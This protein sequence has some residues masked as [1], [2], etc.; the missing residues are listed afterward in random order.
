MMT[1]MKL[2]KPLLNTIAAIMLLSVSNLAFSA[3][4]LIVSGGGYKKPMQAIIAEYQAQTGKQV[5]ASFGNMRQITSQAQASSKIALA[6]G[7]EKFFN[8]TQDLFS[9]S[10]PI[11]EGKLVIAWAQNSP[12]IKT[13]ADLKNPQISRIAL[14]H[15][16]KAI[17]GR[18]A[19]E[20][21]KA[22]KLETELQDVLL[23]ASTIPQV[24]SYLVA[25]EVDAGF[26]NLTDAIGLGQ[27]IGGYTI[28]ENGYSPIKIVAATVKGH[29][30]NPE[31]K[32]F[33]NFLASDKAKQIFNQFGL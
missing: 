24:S 14:P 19:T 31:L 18:A 28:L 1:S 25:R 6:I 10:L 17:Y 26:I 23:Q 16:K 12:Q 30:N 32:A 5:D 33:N 7:D 22:E 29:E 9:N 20:W 4:L 21:L 15:P 11:G 2:F 3:E 27:R 13:P 8:Q